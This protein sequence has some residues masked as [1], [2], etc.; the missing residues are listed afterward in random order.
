M[1]VRTN[2]P[3]VA[4]FLAATGLTSASATQAQVADTIY[5]GGDIVT[6]NE[7]QPSAE[8]VAIKD[9]KILAVGARAVIELAHQGATTQVVRNCETINYRIRRSND[10]GNPS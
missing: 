4:A 2:I 8:A 7:T 5:T 6:V 1:R 10:S 9:G 3:T